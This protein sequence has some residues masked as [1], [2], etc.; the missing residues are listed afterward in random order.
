M[1]YK[2]YA[3][4]LHESGQCKCQEKQWIQCRYAHHGTIVPV[5]EL[6]TKR[7]VRRFNRFC[8]QGVKIS[9]V[10]FQPCTF[11]HLVSQDSG[12]VPPLPFSERYYII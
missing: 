8:V 11:S 3:V 6:N 7:L 5:L 2:S 4:S 12:Y 9:D 1:N 10:P